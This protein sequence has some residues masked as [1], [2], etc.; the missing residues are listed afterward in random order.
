MIDWHAY[1]RAVFAQDRE[2]LP[3]FFAEG[4]EICWHCTDERFTV[5][6][7]VIAN[8]D[9]P[10]EWEGELLRVFDGDPVAMVAKVWAKGGS[11][12]CHVTSFARLQQDMIVRLDEYWADD[13]EAPSWRKELGLGRPI[14]E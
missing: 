13:G 2:E 9:Y 7:F 3:R 6:E 11:V 4:A 14:G 1:W 12:S 10:G 8:C 5:D